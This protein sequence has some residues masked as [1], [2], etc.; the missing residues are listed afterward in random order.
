VT[1][2]ASASRPG[3]Q[4]LAADIDS[5]IVILTDLGHGRSMVELLGEDAAAATRGVSAWGQ[6]LGR[7][8]VATV[9]GE[10]D[11]DALLRHSVRQGS[12]EKSGAGVPGGEVSAQA[13]AARAAVDE[14][15]A[16]IDLSVGERL[17]AELERGLELFVDGD[18][19]AFSPSDVGPENIYINEDGVQF[20]DY[21]F[22]AFRD[23]TLDVAY[24]LVTFPARLAETAI[25]KRAELETGLIDAWRSEAQ[26]VWPGLRRDGDLQRRILTARTLWVWLSTYWLLSGSTGGH[27]WALHTV[28]ARIVLTRWGDLAEA[29][30]RAGDAELESL[31]MDLEQALQRFWFE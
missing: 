11:F 31:A 8:H 16:R 15:A 18:Y 5:R 2:L 26:S 4:L 13:A 6:A 9:T 25:D 24:A 30:H 29:A 22:G 14:I 27:D 17:G 19:R 3:P 21:E 10:D 20:M 12:G 28:D 7:M 23:A 1:A